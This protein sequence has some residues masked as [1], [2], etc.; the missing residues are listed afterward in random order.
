MILSGHLATEGDVARF[1]GEAESAARLDHPGIV[2]IFEVGQHEGQHFYA[3]GFIEGS[4][5]ADRVSQGPLTCAEAAEFMRQLAEAV[6]YAHQR[7]VI[8]RD[9]K[10]ENVLLDAQDQVRV[11]DFGIAKRVD[12]DS[13][14]TATG[15]V[16]GTP[17]Y[18]PPEQASGRLDMIGP[19]SDVY[20]LGAVLYAMLTGRPPI[21]ASTPVDTL[22]QVLERDPIQPRQLNA[23]VDRDLETIC[24]KCL[25]KDIQN[26]YAT[27]REVIAEIERYQRG[28]PLLA[29]PVSPW[30]LLWRW[31]TRLRENKVV[32]VR[33]AGGIGRIP[34]VDIAIGPDIE[35]GETRGVAR[36]V[37]A[38]GDTAW[39]VFAHGESARGFVAF[40]DTAWGG[41]AIGT[42]AIG[43]VSI[44]ALGLGIISISGVSLGLIAIG[45]LAAG[46]VAVG[47]IVIGQYAFG[48]LA[49]GEHVTG[50][51]R[52]DEEGRQFFGRWLRRLFGSF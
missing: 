26:R 35:T 22:V 24:M 19:A 6:E 42:R 17:S 44:G 28:E 46:W 36:G 39:G 50:F 34:W 31:H 5:L 16:L 38:I 52:S 37:I 51:N 32:R 8:H 29:R 4:S 18:M 12:H 11:T 2:P 30:E 23:N 15:Q 33:S 48:A 40:G 41:L 20:S 25:Q 43:L 14:L 47:G 27:A 7:G 10:P 45:G 9:L 3:M 49:L 21:Q 13:Q 1:H